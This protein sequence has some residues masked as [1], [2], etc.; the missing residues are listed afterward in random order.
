[1]VIF[2]ILPFFTY[3]LSSVFHTQKKIFPSSTG[4]NYNSSYKG[5]INANSSFSITN[6]LNKE[7]VQ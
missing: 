1:M 2:L 6:F 4:I 5:W 7:L 3:L